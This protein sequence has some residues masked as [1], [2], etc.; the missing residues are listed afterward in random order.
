[1]RQLPDLNVTKACPPHE[2][3]VFIDY[4]AWYAYFLTAPVCIEVTST[5]LT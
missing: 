5:L 1:M 4:A 2:G 3:P